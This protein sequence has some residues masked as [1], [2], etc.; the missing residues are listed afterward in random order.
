[1]RKLAILFLIIFNC[2]CV[3]AQSNLQK[4]YDTEKAF[5]R[6]AAEKGVRAAFIEYLAPDGIMFRPNPVNG[7]E[8]WK[9]RPETPAQLLWNPTFVDVSSNGALGYTTGNS[10]FRPK[11]KDDP[12]AF[13][14]EYATVWQRQPDGSYL[15]AL[16]LGI[17][18][19]KPATIETEWKSPADS[20]KEL[21]EKKFSAADASTAFFETAT[22]QGL[23]RAY[24][25]FLA[26]DARLLREGKQPILGKQN[27]LAEFKNDKTQ[28]FFAKRSVF[29]GAADM[30]YVS[31]S[32]TVN[33]RSG[34]QIGK[35]NFLQIWKLR[36]GKWQIV[37]DVFVPTPEPKN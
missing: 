8:F 15:A 11:G 18:H 28:T 14:G 26:E 29:V 30:A 20:G 36:S 33:D 23:S 32:Y 7:R 1:M 31:N 9:N 12:N 22:K 2:A 13:Y 16:D 5:E 24:K 4:L 19:E 21:N 6:A 17:S 10:I 25:T 3:F 37:L 34:K 27:A 35:G